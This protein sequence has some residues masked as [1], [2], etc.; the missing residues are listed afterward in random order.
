MSDTNKPPESQTELIIEKFM[1]N[2]QSH[3]EFDEKTLLKLKELASSGNLSQYKKIE[4]V[5][6]TQPGGGNE[7]N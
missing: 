1:E 7:D 5:I 4:V 6:K 3:P 2:L